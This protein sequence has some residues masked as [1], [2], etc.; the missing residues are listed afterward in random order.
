[1]SDSAHGMRRN[2]EVVGTEPQSCC[3][4]T[5]S[6]RWGREKCAPDAPQCGCRNRSAAQPTRRGGGARSAPPSRRNVAAIELP[7]NQLGAVGARV[8]RPRRAAM[9]PQS[10]C[11]ATNSARW[12]REKCAPDAPQC[13]CRNRADA[14]PTRRGGRARS[15]RPPRRN[16][17]GI[18]L[19]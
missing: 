9:R 14:Q 3:R 11:R 17:G 8:V 16:V 1:M 10:C 18:F 5:N 19:V 12:G 4:A 2:E 6:A 15:A 7:R 13:G